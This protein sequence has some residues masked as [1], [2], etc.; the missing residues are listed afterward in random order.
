MS[1]VTIRGIVKVK[2]KTS[3]EVIG[4]IEHIS[5]NYAF[6]CIR[7]AVSEQNILYNGKP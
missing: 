3:Q 6:N 4:V 2:K 5:L 1:W 7:K